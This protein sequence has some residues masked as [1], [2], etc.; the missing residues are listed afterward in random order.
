MSAELVRLRRQVA[1]L[2]LD[3]EILKRAAVFF[4]HETH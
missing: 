2:E 4:A 1:Q 3:K